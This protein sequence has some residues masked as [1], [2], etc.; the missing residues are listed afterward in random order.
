MRTIALA[1]QKGGVGKST[2]AV[3]LGAALAQLKKR[4]LL[5]DL[6]P[7]CTASYWLGFKNPSKGLFDLFTEN[8]KIADII[9]N[10][11]IKGLDLIVGSPWLISADKMLASEVGAETILKK[12][13]AGLKEEPD[14]V[15]VDCPPQIG[16][17]LLN[18]L[19]AADG[20]LVPVVPDTLAIQGLAALLR[21]IESVQER[22]NASLELDGLLGCRVKRTRLS[23]GILEDLRKR[24]GKQVYKTTIRE[25]VKVAESHSHSMP[26]TKYDPKGNGAT[27]YLALAKEI[28]RR[29]GK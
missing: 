15:L 24:F 26:I 7:Q 8:T 29:K 23:A 14:F 4:V 19:T 6:D 3:N 13:L 21:T 22:L 12:K 28:I 20:V 9:E 11:S 5:L 25:S 10:T 18:G 17:L 27:D 16:T 2:T 1:N